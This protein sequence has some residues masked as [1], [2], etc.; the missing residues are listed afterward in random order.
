[1]QFR[2][3][4]LEDYLKSTDKFN[5]RWYDKYITRSQDGENAASGLDSDEL[6]YCN[7]EDQVE[8]IF[9]VAETRSIYYAKKII[10]DMLNGEFELR[11]AVK[12]NNSNSL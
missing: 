4:V 7:S 1:M 9:T 6:H 5:S 2:S 3:C 12:D 8:D 11:E 10:R